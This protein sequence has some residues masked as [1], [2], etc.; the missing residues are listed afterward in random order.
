[1]NGGIVLSYQDSRPLY[2]Q[3]ADDMRKKIHNGDWPAGEKLPTENG[4]C[5]LYHVSRI[6]IRKAINELSIERLV[7]TKRPVGTFVNSVSERKPPQYTLVK[8]FT[9]EMSELG[10]NFRTFSATIEIS[11]A[12]PTMAANLH[13]L[14]GSKILVLK[15]LRGTLKEPFA[16]FETSFTFSEQF[17][18]AS[19]DY[20]QSFYDYLSQ[21]SIHPVLSQEYIE[22]G[23]A[24]QHVRNM[25]RIRES[26]P[27]LKRYRLTNDKA[28]NFF[29]FSKC[30]YIGSQYR[31]YVDFSQE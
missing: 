23:L 31:Y 29:E 16:Y 5:T 30:Y 12:D 26:E 9:K 4:L 7:H 24:D 15:R 2:A 13:T 17:S 20:Y 1:M 11:H 21:F 18:L 22:A 14:P 6:T 19:S 28:H 8:S 25:L 3:I 27:I 10:L